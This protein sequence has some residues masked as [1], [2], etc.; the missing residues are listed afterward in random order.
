MKKPVIIFDFDGVIVDSFD[1]VLQ[2]LQELHKKY[3]LPELT[4]AGLRKLFEKNIWES[5]EA[6]DLSE[7][8]LASLKRDIQNKLT[9]RARSIGIFNGVGEV[10][11]ELSQ[12]NT[13]IILTSNSETATKAKLASEEILGFFDR[14]IGVETPGN[15]QEKMEKI[16]VD[17]GDEAFLVTD[18]VG[19]LREASELPLQRIAVAWGYHPKELLATGSPDIIVETPEALLRYFE[20]Q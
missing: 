11:A 2:S 20:V 1:I 18:T 5:Y 13:L 14:I 19:D 4:A 16:I 9:E 15:K 17:S 8:E 12:N 7:E 10:L 6:F 3:E